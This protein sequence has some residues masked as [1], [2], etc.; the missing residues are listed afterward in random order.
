MRNSNGTKL[1][2][3]DKK[4][5]GKI[6]IIPAILYF[7]ANFVFKRWITIYVICDFVSSIPVN[8]GPSGRALRRRSAAARLLR[9]WVRIPW[10]FVCCEC[11]ML[12]G[13]RL[14][15]ELIP[16]PEESYQLW[17]V[18]VCDPETSWIRRPWPTGR[19]AVAPKK[20]SKYEHKRL[21]NKSINPTSD[22]WQ[23]HL[24]RG[25]LGARRRFHQ[26]LM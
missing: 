16:R 12:S 23:P 25:P 6:A 21:K 3:Q 15:D 11:D 7:A 18:V 13:R 2:E 19:R 9:L 10:M 24:N 26:F 17:C 8:A 14:C 4:Y 5:T 20:S 1:W 22:F